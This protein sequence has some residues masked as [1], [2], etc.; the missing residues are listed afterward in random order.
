METLPHCW[1]ECKLVKPLWKRAWKFLKKLSM[2]WSSRHGTVETNLTRKHED[3]GSVPD[4]GNFHMLWAWPDI[5]KQII[6]R[7][8]H[9]GTVVNEFD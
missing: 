3:V 9:H 6:L 4:P 7:S 1:W 2:E 8:S 5:N